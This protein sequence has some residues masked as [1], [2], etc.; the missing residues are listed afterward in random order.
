MND[1]TKDIIL[2]ILKNIQSDI[3]GVKTNISGFQSN[4]ASMKTDIATAKEH[5]GAISIRLTAVESHMSGFMAT[6]KYH[7]MELDE[8]RGRIEALEGKPDE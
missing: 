6:S 7:E 5:L 4:I 3:S 8:L 2:P 1:E